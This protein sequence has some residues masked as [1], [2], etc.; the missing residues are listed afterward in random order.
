MVIDWL[1]IKYDDL[2]RKKTNLKGK[3]LKNGEKGKILTELRG[4][5]I[6]LKKGGAG[7][8]KYL[9]GGNIHPC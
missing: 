8:Q 3:R 9:S 5:N 7:G 6:I 2:S 4:K 1:G